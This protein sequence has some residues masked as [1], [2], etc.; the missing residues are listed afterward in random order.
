MCFRESSQFKMSKTLFSFLYTLITLV[1][2]AGIMILVFVWEGRRVIVGDDEFGNYCSGT[3]PLWA[4]VVGALFDSIISTLLCVLFVRQL[5]KV[6]LAC[7]GMNDATN[8]KW[9]G[10]I[11]KYV[12][13]TVVGV[14]STFAVFFVFGL[15]AWFTFV[16]IDHSVNCWCIFLMYRYNRKLFRCI[17]SGCY[18]CIGNCVYCCIQYS[19]DKELEMTEF[20]HVY[21]E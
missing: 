21:K 3:A 19:K 10:N 20:M 17:C 13:L 12:T 2:V 14:G 6:H 1:S 11:A 16:A 8:D 18:K 9:I 15:T 7:R 5:F 4:F